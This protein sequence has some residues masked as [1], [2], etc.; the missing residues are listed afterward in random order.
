[1]TVLR[2]SWIDV[3]NSAFLGLRFRKMAVAF[4]GIVISY[5]WWA[6]F[7]YLA[8]FVQGIPLQRIWIAYGL[9]PWP[10]VSTLGNEW[11]G[12]LWIV[13]CAGFAVAW[14]M[15]TAA[16]SRISF[17]QLRGNEF[18]SWAEAWSFSLKRMKTL[19]TSP[20]TL[21]GG[22]L[23]CL[24]MLFIASYIARLWIPLAGVLFIVAFPIALV[25]L[26]L[27]LSGILAL[28]YTPAIVA[29]SNSHTLETVFETLSMHAGQGRRGWIY[30]FISTVMATLN[31]V[32]FG[33][34][35]IVVSLITTWVLDF[36]RSGAVGTILK[37]ASAWM[38][39]IASWL[40]GVPGFYDAAGKAL[41]LIEQAHHN[42]ALLWGT[43]SAAA[44]I[45]TFWLYLLFFLTCSQFAATFG[46]CSITAY[47]IV[48]QY[49][50]EQNLLEEDLPS[51]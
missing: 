47:V 39:R 16:V 45:M 14:L 41:G 6:V 34:L 27:A 35:L 42:Y 50:D 30:A 7:S 18:T 11:S 43:S 3:I 31:T 23:L 5:I 24:V 51:D 8:L 29:S 1:L 4:P 10:T 26:Y 40:N 46:S 36:G 32:F 20:A 2:Y 38:P 19:A 15:A 37:Q 13:G 9:F 33:G 21:F 49:K 25:L 22:A 28:A 17:E 48:R 12:L 44:V